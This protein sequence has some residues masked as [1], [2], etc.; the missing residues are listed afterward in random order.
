MDLQELQLERER[1]RARNFRVVV[2]TLCILAC[3]FVTEVDFL[4]L[5]ALF[6]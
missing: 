3:T 6:K 2:V 5:I 1:I 4:A